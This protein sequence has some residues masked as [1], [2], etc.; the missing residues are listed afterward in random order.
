MIQVKNLIFSY[1]EQTKKAIDDISCTFKTGE[2]V[3]I[4]GHNGSGKSTLSKLL[5]GLLKPHSGEIFISGIKIER[6]SLRKIRSLIGIVFQ[7]PENQF[8]GSTVE[9]D[10][11]FGLENK[12]MSRA[13]M[14]RVVLNLSKD[15]GIDKF[16]SKEPHNLSGG[17]KQRV[18]I[19]STLALDPEI[20]IF[21]EVTSMLDP[22]G[23]TDILKIIHDVQKTKKKTL[24]SITHD[25]DEALLADRV[26]V[27][28]AGKIIAFDTPQKILCNDKIIKLAKIDNP[29]IY[30]ISKQLSEVSKIKITFSEKELLGALC[31]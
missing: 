15:V 30:K 25:M 28:S 21:D 18:A 2:H 27:M 23:K 19:A 20:I 3:A 10:I 29:F 17:Q 4:I 5:V 1:S 26:V 9:D 13:E 14:R 24:I 11:A 8:V 6:K 16:L 22:K 12:Q 7:N 31:K